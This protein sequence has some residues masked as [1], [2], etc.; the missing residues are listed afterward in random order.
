MLVGIV[1]NH[2]CI[3]LGSPLPLSGFFGNLYKNLLGVLAT[4]PEEV[5]SL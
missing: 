2:V 1:A 4:L 5:L 3:T